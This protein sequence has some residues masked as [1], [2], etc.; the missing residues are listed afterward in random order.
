M[1]NPR[2]QLTVEKFELLSLFLYLA[3]VG[4]AEAILDLREL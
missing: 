3:C 1:S 2:R 4:V